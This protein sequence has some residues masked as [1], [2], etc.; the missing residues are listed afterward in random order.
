MSQ[1]PALLP[2]PFKRQPLKMVKHTQVMCRRIADKLFEY[3]WPFC[4]FGSYKPPFKQI[5][6]VQSHLLSFLKN[7]K[8]MRETFELI[9]ASAVWWSLMHKIYLM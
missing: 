8:K 2:Q 6:S 4:V 5:K 9:K 7:K 3:V 1:L